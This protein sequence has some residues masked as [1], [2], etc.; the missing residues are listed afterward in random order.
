MACIT[1]N[2]H[3]KSRDVLTHPN[4]KLHGGLVLCWGIDDW[5]HKTKQYGYEYLS[6]YPS[7]LFSQYYDS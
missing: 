7:K 4:Y 6:M 3:E 1:K 2:F 5:L